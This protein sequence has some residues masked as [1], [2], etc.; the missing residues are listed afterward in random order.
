MSS[1]ASY[2][3]KNARGNHGIQRGSG[4]FVIHAH[5]LL[6]VLMVIMRVTPNARSSSFIRAHPIIR[7]HP[8]TLRHLRSR[9]M[10]KEGV[11][12]NRLACTRHV[13]NCPEDRSRPLTDLRAAAAQGIP[14]KSELTTKASREWEREL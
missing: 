1:S 12:E 11:R 13:R 4:C 8:M 14:R 10:L 5:P 6:Y 3:G 9:F 7:A 2:S